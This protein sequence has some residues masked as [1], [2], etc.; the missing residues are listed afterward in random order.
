MWVTSLKPCTS[1]TQVIVITVAQLRHPRRRFA[2][3]GK[4]SIVANWLRNINHTA[5]IISVPKSS[6]CFK[7]STLM[8]CQTWRTDVVLAL[9]PEWQ[10]SCLS[11]QGSV[12]SYRHSGFPV[13][14]ETLV[15]RFFTQHSPKPTCKSWKKPQVSPPRLGSA[16]ADGSFPATSSQPRLPDKRLQRVCRKEGKSWQQERRQ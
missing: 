7:I 1:C 12:Y 11:Q 9:G 3:F 6:E 5:N 2:K 15:S 4:F 16:E 10:R 14:H 13:K 8:T